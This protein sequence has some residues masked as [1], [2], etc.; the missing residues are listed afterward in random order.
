MADEGY[1]RRAGDVDRD[2]R[3]SCRRVSP[4]IS[5]TVDS[6]P[7]RDARFAAP[8]AP[9]V[10][11]GCRN[12]VRSFPRLSRTAGRGRRRPAV[13]YA[14]LAFLLHAHRQPRRSIAGHIAWPARLAARRA[15]RRV[16]RAA[17]CSGPESEPLTASSNTSPRYVEITYWLAQV[18]AGPST[19]RGGR[20]IVRHRVQV[21]AALAGGDRGAGQ[22]VFRVRRER[23]RARVLRPHAGPRTRSSGGVN[24]ASQGPQ[25]L[26]I[27]RRRRLPQ[28]MR[29]WRGKR[30]SFQESS[31]TGVRGTL[32]R[33]R[34]STLPGRPSNAPTACG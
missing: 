1:L 3:G 33:S 34:T 6:L 30:G 10:C 18:G 5:M 4:I 27:G 22:P 16:P 14:W 29:F 12:C 20:A 32:R 9:T 11:A 28:S 7:R 24:R 2:A 25:P 8:S 26:S 31:I 21:A 13:A 17:T 15:D 23:A 19:D